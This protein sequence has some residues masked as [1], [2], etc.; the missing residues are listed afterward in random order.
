M[1]ETQKKTE[2]VFAEKKA[3]A[4]IFLEGKTREEL[5]EQAANFYAAGSVAVDALGPRRPATPLAENE[6]PFPTEGT[7]PI[8]QAL[9]ALLAVTDAWVGIFK[10]NASEH[11]NSDE[12][13]KL[14]PMTFFA[15]T[16]VRPL[17]D[18]PE[19]CGDAHAEVMGTESDTGIPF[20]LQCMVTCAAY[21]V[22]T[23]KTE[24]AG[25]WDQAWLC[26]TK[27]KYWAGVVLGS[28]AV[29]GKG[30]SPASALA[31]MRHAENYA[32][33]E[34]VAKFWREHIDPSLSAQKAAEQVFR[35]NVVPF[36]YKKIAEIISRL[37]K[38]KALRTT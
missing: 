13:E 30:D 23:I 1:D 36:S 15:V 26:A 25:D 20:G 21:V 4:L 14:D 11:L 7:S 5:L 6:I 16:V 34:D 33:A 3:E 19:T 28:M 22:Q 31:K 37:R 38:E 32:L 24:K 27:A 29:K 35:A 18:D 2:A 17:F 9:S 12:G 8:K 10:G